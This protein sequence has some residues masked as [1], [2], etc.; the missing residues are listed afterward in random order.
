VL[1][2]RLSDIFHYTTDGRIDLPRRSQ[3]IESRHAVLVIGFQ[4]GA[5]G[6]SGDF[7]FRNSWGAAW[8]DSGYGYLPSEY[9]E[10]HAIAARTVEA[11]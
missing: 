1:A 3:V 7:I 4:P 6:S 11:K 5:S 10:R 8:G 9:V 2:V